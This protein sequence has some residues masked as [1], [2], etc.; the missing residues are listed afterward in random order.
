MAKI[1]HRTSDEFDERNLFLQASLGMISF[2]RRVERLI[3]DAAV[4][5]QDRV[6]PQPG[7]VN[8]S[9]STGS[10]PCVDLVL[11]LV[12]FTQRVH[13]H[14]EQWCVVAPRRAPADSAGGARR[15]PAPPPRDLFL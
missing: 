11:G 7:P 12:A 13:H 2:V 14:L 1:L 8:G 6:A 10:D 3:D 5:A 15:P 4:E 9:E